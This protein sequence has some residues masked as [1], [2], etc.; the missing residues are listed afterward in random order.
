MIFL[1]CPDYVHYSSPKAPIRVTTGGNSSFF[2]GVPDWV[3]EEEVLK[4]DYA[5]W[6][7]PDAQSIAFLAL[8]ETKVPVYDVPVYNPS[9]DSSE[10]NPYP[11]SLT[12]RY[13]KVR[14]HQSFRFD[15]L[16]FEVFLWIA[17]I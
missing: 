14:N 5:L 2:H 16:N 10:V 15:F 4:G 8:D 13:P 1:A 12:M 6:W 9:S 11:S 3:Y 7:S 17:W